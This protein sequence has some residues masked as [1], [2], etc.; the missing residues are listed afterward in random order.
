MDVKVTAA[1]S[2]GVINFI[3][4]VGNF[5]YASN[6]IKNL[7]AQI[8]KIDEYMKKLEEGVKRMDI[9]IDDNINKKSGGFDSRI[10]ALSGMVDN[11]RRSVIEMKDLNGN[12]IAYLQTAISSL[13]LQDDEKKVIAKILKN[14][15]TTKKALPV[16]Q[17]QQGRQQHQQGRQQHQQGRQGGGRNVT[18]DDED[19]NDNDDDED[20][21]D[22]Y[23]HASPSPP[24]QRRPLPAQQKSSR[25]PTPQ[26]DDDDDED[27]VRKLDALREQ[28]RQK[29]QSA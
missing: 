17:Q 26:N 10:T 4:N 24:P 22:E 7:E 25:K 12:N 5:V 6:R 18:F 14:I 15:K 13:P 16:Q 23:E 20:D 2:L 28:K 1:L 3:F 9:T 11:L 21:E 19:D 8:A 29:I 27:A